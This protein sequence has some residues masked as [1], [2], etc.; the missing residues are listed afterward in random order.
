MANVDIKKEPAQTLEKSEARSPAE[1]ERTRERMVFSPSA[2]IYERGDALVVAVDMP[3]V[4]EN[5]VEIN[6]ERRILTING[7]VAPEQYRNYRLTYAEYE[8]GDFERSFTLNEEVDV[9]KIEATVKNGVLRLVL[10]KAEETKPKKIAVK[11]G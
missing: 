3:G 2:D 5:S 9:N 4:D 10:P 11:A 8:T 1:T 6:V 7:Q